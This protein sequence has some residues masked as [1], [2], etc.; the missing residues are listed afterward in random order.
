[1]FFAIH[2]HRGDL[3][4]HEYQ[5]CCQ[6]GWR[7]AGQKAPPRIS[8]ERINNPSAVRRFRWLEK[9]NKQLITLLK[10]YN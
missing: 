6:Q 1:V 5:N 8:T 9:E 4:I 7:N 3:L 2:D 10:Q